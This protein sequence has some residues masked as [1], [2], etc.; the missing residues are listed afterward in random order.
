MHTSLVCTSATATSPR[1]RERLGCGSP[2]TVSTW[3]PITGTGASLPKRLLAFL[4]A[5]A[6]GALVSALAFELFQEAFHKAG[7]VP[8]GIGMVAGATVFIVLD[9]LLDRRMSRGATGFALLVAVTLDGVPENLALGT[10]IAAGAGSL[11]LL[12]A[13]FAS[14]FPEALVGAQSMLDDGRSARFAVATWLGAGLLLA[15]A[16]VLGTAAASNV[17]EGTLSVVLAFAGGAVL[18]SLVDTIMPEAY[19]DGGP[20]VAFATVAGFLVSFL[21]GEASGM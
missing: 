11:P 1:C 13:I 10:T 20:L 8:A 16:V 15:A 19:R 9:V 5:F 14:N 17:G 3:T 21:L 2:S 6:A 7:A 18:A 4:L 12:V